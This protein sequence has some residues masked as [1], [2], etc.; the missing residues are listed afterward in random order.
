MN[1]TL[2][3]RYVF[4]DTQVFLRHGIQFDRSSLK[5]LRELASW[6]MIN[7][8]LTDVVV[9]EVKLKIAEKTNG[10]KLI[11]NKFLRESG[12]I[13]EKIPDAISAINELIDEDELEK[14]GQSLWDD[15]IRNSKA[16]VISSSTVDTSLL[17]SKYFSGSP[18]FSA[19][20]KDEFP[21]AISLLSLEK[22]SENYEEGIYVVSGDGDVDAWCNN[23]TRFHYLKSLNDFIDLYNRTEEKLTYLVHEIFDAEKNWLISIIEDEFKECEFSYRPDSEAH[24]ENINVLDIQFNDLNVIEVDEERALLSI[25]IHID[26]TADVS[27]HDYDS[28]IWDSE[29]KEFVYVPT[30]NSTIEDGEFF[31]VTAEV[32][33]DIVEK[34]FTHADAILF[35][36]SSVIGFGHDE[37]PYK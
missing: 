19:K 25:G 23:N 31:E 33:I 32:Y 12:F 8:V 7:L 36:D 17:I 9:N 5:R 21:D 6:K 28:G 20:K 37:F 4:I 22:F 18:P 27:G 11:L 3:S 35:D 14:H 10:S 1:E 15:Y 24:V 13:S 26:F 34:S 2:K 16:I 30:Y 29:D